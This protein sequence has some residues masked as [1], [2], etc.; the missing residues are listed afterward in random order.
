MTDTLFKLAE[1][2]CL[3][4]S[5]W[6]EDMKLFSLFLPSSALHPAASTRKTL[7]ATVNVKII[8]GLKLS[9]AGRNCLSLL[10]MRGGDVFH[11]FSFI[12]EF[13]HRYKVQFSQQQMSD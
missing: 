9:E 12:S 8:L 4:V 6:K 3:S 1:S 7:G 13:S 5:C 11:S 2:L 10:L